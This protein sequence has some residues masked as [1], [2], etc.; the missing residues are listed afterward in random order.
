MDAE[1]ALNKAMDLIADFREDEAET[2][3]QAL[4]QA[5]KS[6]MDATPADADRQFHWGR[7]LYLLE[8]P[9]QALLRFEQALQI[10]PDHEGALWETVSILLHDLDKPE[11]AKIILEQRLLP[12]RPN[13]PLYA[14]AL[15]AAET[16]I[17][18][19]QG[20]EVL[21]WDPEQGPQLPD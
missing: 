10:R 7:S 16:L 21:P 20:R 13:H 12:L 15:A 9:E 14:E 1:Q 8:E 5:L 3:L 19:R 6:D 4:I 11:S 17:R 18:R 2:T